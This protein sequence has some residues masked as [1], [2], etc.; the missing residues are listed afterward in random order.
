MS[1][2]EI[3]EN[4]RMSVS[5]IIDDDICEDDDKSHIDSS[6]FHPSSSSSSPPS[7]PSS[8]PPSSPPSQPSSSSEDNTSTT[9]SE[10]NITMT[11]LEDLN[12]NSF[13]VDLNPMSSLSING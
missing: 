2:A 7:T 6:I 13:I 5:T 12:L 4:I 3:Q 8:S 11:Q 10:N 1:D 9:S